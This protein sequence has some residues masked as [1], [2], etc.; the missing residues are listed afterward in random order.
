MK[1]LQICLS[2]LVGV[3]ILASCVPAAE[4]PQP[5][6]TELASATIQPNAPI[7]KTPTQSV[8][9]IPPPTRRLAPTVQGTATMT[10]LASFTI[11]PTS[12]N[13]KTVTSTIT[14]TGTLYVR[15]P[16]FGG[17]TWSPTPV[18]FKCQVIGSSPDWGHV[19]KPRSNFI[20]IW[21]LYNAGASM[22]HEGDLID[23]YVS[24]TKMQNPDRT[25]NIL[26]HTVYAKDFLDFRIQ[27]RPPKDP[28]IYT[29][30]WGLR[31]TNKQD[32]FCTFSVTIQV[33]K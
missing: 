19:Y 30:T 6:N 9:P 24:G 10:P 15:P 3:F 17:P 28:G 7:T 26:D 18:S 1:S 2:A 14:S 23:G 31:K 27:L 21:R 13:T 33:A 22:W 8:T 20:A 4:T 29:L 12:K 5:Q 11:K 25:G 16:G 32:F